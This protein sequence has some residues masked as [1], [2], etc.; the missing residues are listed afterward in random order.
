MILNLESDS[1]FQIP[2]SGSLAYAPL[3]AHALSA[4]P[5]RPSRSLHEVLSTRFADPVTP[6]TWHCYIYPRVN[7]PT[8]LPASYPPIYPPTEESAPVCRRRQ[9]AYWTRPPMRTV[10]ILLETADNK[11]AR[12]RVADS[13][14]THIHLPPPQLK[15][16]VSSKFP[17]APL[18]VEFCP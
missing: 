12:A 2:R 9:A 10:E 16:E 3:P 8:Y 4:G 13:T 7:L 5:D 15:F 11:T 17:E 1:V 14:F 18:L 6:I